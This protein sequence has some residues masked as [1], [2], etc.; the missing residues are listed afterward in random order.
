MLLQKRIGCCV[1][2]FGATTFD[3]GNDP[4]ILEAYLSTCG[5][6]VMNVVERDPVF[7]GRSSAESA[8][9]SIHVA[10]PRS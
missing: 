9:F 2:E 4:D 7:P 8:R 1:F 3:M 5:Y 6:R 10:S